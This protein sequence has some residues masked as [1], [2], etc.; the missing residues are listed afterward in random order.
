MT[1][2][3]LLSMISIFI[4]KKQNGGHLIIK[5]G[6]FFPLFMAKKNGKIEM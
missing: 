4:N 1:V 5:K 6:V 2:A 3:L